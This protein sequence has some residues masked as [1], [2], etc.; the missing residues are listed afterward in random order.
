MKRGQL[1]NQV[2]IYALAAITFGLVLIYGYNAVQ[3]IQ[4]KS[5]Y[6]AL[7]ELKSELETTVDE[8]AITQNVKEW[9]NT[10]MPTGYDKLCFIDMRLDYESGYGDKC[11][12]GSY[13]KV[14]CNAWKDNVSSNVYLVPMADVAFKTVP[15]ELVN[16]SKYPNPRQ[17]VLCLDVTS[18]V[19]KLK[20]TGK[21]D[22]T[23][24]EELIG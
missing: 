20:L 1:A 4:E 14:V 23:V 22:R 12:D 7:V 11:R 24:V 2:F 16:R 3:S 21:G 9:R 13:P 10:N 19:L 18:G 17:G 8:I 15:V 5:N 6:V